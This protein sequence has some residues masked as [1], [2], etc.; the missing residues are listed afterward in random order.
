M[1]TK[2]TKESKSKA[3]QEISKVEPFPNF[4][5]PSYW[6]SIEYKQDDYIRNQQILK[7]IDHKKIQADRKKYRKEAEAAKVIKILDSI[8]F[9]SRED[10]NAVFDDLY[11][12]L[13]N[14][15]LLFEALGR[16]KN[17]KGITTAGTDGETIDGLSKETITKII[18]DLKNNTYQF[19]PVLRVYIPK[20]GKKEKRP[21]GIP[22]LRDKILQSAIRIILEA[23]YE[24]L[25]I[26]TN[27]NYGFR[28]GLGCHHAI[29]K[30][31]YHCQ[32]KTVTIEGDIL[33]AFN[34]VKFNILI[35]ILKK[36]IKDNKFLNLILKLLQS[37]IMDKNKY[38]K[39]IMGTPQGGIV[40]PLLFNIYMH[41]FDL[42]ITTEL[43]KTITQT[44]TTENRKEI[45]DN[46]IYRSHRY[47]KNQLSNRIRAISTTNPERALEL[48]RAYRQ[49]SLQQVKMAPWQL[50]K[51]HHIHIYQI[52]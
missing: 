12:L 10:H 42:Y 44:N 35:N 31:K 9:K 19:K 8:V 36:K 24:P 34:N 15:D 33:G 17:N 14:E 51:E 28:P 30:I 27:C 49:M 4:N 26:T 20:P 41:E 23:I 11:N 18:L 45:A 39:T 22:T 5:S 32:A 29:T 38:S 43:A 37:G 46:P 25:F 40:S 52:C 16:I 1:P 47:Y 2:Q 21:L 3:K 13:Q 48:K 6:K 50:H 7:A